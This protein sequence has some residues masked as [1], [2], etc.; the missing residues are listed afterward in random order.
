MAETGR[1]IILGDTPFLAYQ[2]RGTQ[3]RGDF[4]FT[5]EAHGSD[6]LAH[7]GEAFASDSGLYENWFNLR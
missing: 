3:L 5:R 6:P 7:K 1:K 2:A 4:I